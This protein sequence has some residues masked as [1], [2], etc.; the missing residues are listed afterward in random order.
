[1]HFTRRRPARFS[2]AA[3]WSQPNPCPCGYLGH[4][5]RA[6]QD[7]RDQIQRYRSRI[8]GPLLDRIDCH[9]EVPAQTPEQLNSGGNGPS[10]A[11]IREQVEAA[12]TRMPTRQG[13]PNGHLAGAAL[14]THAEPHHQRVSYSI[15]RWTN[16]DC[17][18]AHMTD[19]ASRTNHYRP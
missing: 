15:R 3:C 4:P 7:S 8:S 19:P 17:L 14:R 9:V 1:M 11:S 18:H 5:T 10:S 2:A 13:C 6:C 16:S 12:R